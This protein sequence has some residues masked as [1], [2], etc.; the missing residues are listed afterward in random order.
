MVSSS[1]PA[2]PSQ[3]IRLAPL[4]AARRGRPPIGFTVDVA[5]ELTVEQPVAA[6]APFVRGHEREGARVVGELE[7]DVFA[8]SLVMDADRALEDV[9]LA[10]LDGLGAGGV[11]RARAPQ[12]VELEDGVHAVRLQ[13]DRLRE[14]SGA[15]PALPYVTIVALAGPSVRGGVLVTAC[16]ADDRWDAGE[17]AI[18]SVRVLDQQR[19]GGG[20]GGTRMPLA[21][22]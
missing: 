9:A 16:A 20:R 7:I 11:V 12:H 19:G 1:A 15:R 5:A 3:T 13:A 4:T 8:A 17:R 22:R 2:R 10:A 18:D 14:A 6:N 21:S